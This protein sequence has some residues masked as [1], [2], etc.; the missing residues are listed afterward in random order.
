MINRYCMIRFKRLLLFEC[1]IA[2]CIGL[3]I[4]LSGCDSSSSHSSESVQEES[5]ALMPERF[6]S[7]DV[8]HL[9]EQLADKSGLNAEDVIRTY[10]PEP[11]Q[12]EGHEKIT[13]SKK[14]LENG[15]IQITLIHSNLPDDSMED[16][17]YVMEAAQLSSHWM[18]LSLKR[19]WRCREGRG[20]REWGIQACQ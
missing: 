17:K 10:Y 14:E 4:S 20:P 8:G 19:N 3:N 16:T 12:S 13:I 15:N 18:V 9:N 11:I 7:I 2:L 6:Q 5:L 1:A